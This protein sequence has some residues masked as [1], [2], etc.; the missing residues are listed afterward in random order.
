MADQSK[1]ESPQIA[2]E[3]WNTKLYDDKFYNPD[4]EALA[5]FKLETG[6]ENDEE[7]KQHILTVQKGAFSV[8]SY[9][10]I[11]IFEFMR[12]K[13]ARLPAYDHVLTLGRERPDGIF[14]D[15][16]CS[17]GNDSRKLVRDGYPVQNILAV[18][19]RRELWNLGHELFRSTP[20]TFPVPFIKGDILDPSFITPTTLSLSLSPN[21]TCPDL[22]TLTSL[23][24]LRG[25]LS[26]IYTGAFFHLFDF[27]QQLY[28]AQCL[29]SLL[30]SEP[31]SIIIG[32]QGGMS[33]KGM[34]RPD[35]S[36]YAMC[37]HSVESWEELWRGV[38]RGGGEGIRVSARLREEIGGITFFDTWPLNTTKQYH[39]LEWAVI[40]V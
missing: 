15:L 21:N 34:W 11:R 1:T 10:C 2:N 13:L 20:H 23:N 35:G 19:L 40:R 28:I 3:T 5:F 22:S 4:P 30:S 17:F 38:F 39:V 7:L 36:E 31:G 14:L 33:E 8:Y 12:L 24:P 29:A 6:I 9:P 32:V 26:A 16:G 25:H 18:D 27:S 37:C